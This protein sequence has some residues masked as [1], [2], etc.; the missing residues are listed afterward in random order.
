MT[1]ISCSMKGLSCMQIDEECMSP[2]HRQMAL[3]SPCRLCW[4]H[5][6][7]SS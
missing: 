5:I 7:V 6:A 4:L 3:E 1:L 2:G